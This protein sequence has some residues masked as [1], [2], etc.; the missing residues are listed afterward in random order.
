[1]EDTPGPVKSGEARREKT[2][3]LYDIYKK[4]AEDFMAQK[5]YSKALKSYNLVTPNCLPDFVSLPFFS[6]GW[7]ACRG[8]S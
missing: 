2:E 1:M 5:Q 4:E 7:V 6:T 8:V 3:M